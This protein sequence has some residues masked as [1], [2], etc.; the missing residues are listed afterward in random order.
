MAG[1]RAFHPDPVEEE[2][3]E[4]IRDLS[5]YVAFRPYRTRY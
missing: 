5:R 1:T 3:R 2:E 4:R